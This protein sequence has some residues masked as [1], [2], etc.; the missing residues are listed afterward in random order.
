VVAA[1][2][3]LVAAQLVIRGWAAWGGF[4][5][6][7]DFVLQSRSA[8]LS[9][10]GAELLLTDVDGRLMPAGMVV[11]W[12]TTQVA[13]LS[14]VGVVIGLVVMQAV[15]SLAVWA[16][17][18]RL[19]GSRTLMLVPLGLYLLT[20]LT[21]PSFLWWTSALGS[22]PLQAGLALAVWAHVGYLRSGRRSDLALAWAVTVGALAFSEKAALIPI[23]LVGVTWILDRHDGTARSLWWA[24]AGRWRLW[25]A[26]LVVVAGYVS[27]YR[28]TVGTPPSVGGSTGEWW[29]FARQGFVDAFWVPLVGGPVSWLPVGA[30]SALA[31]PPGW[32][33]VLAAAALVAVV[34]S[35]WRMSPRA[36]RA[37]LFVVGYVAVDLVVIAAVRG[38]GQ[39]TDLAPLTLRYTADAAVVA[40]I[41]VGVS[42]MSSPGEPEPPRRAALLERVARRPTHAGLALFLVVDVF[43]L[44]TTISTLRLASIWAA[45]PAEG[46]VSNA[47]RTLAEAPP[48]EPV[49]PQPVPDTVLSPFAYPDNLTSRVLA[50]V[51][52]PGQFAWQT[53]ALTAF[54]ASG[55]LLPAHVAG[56]SAPLPPD[57]SCWLASQGRGLVPLDAAL[58]PFEHVVRLAY[59]A[60][61]QQEGT[62]ALGGGDAVP[63]EFQRGLSDLFLVLTGGGT[64]LYVTLRELGPTVCISQADVGNVVP[65]PR[66]PS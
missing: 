65:G 44:L 55:T 25:L 53:S 9:F 24:L 47:T 14:Q 62:V 12:V 19:F 15:A 10:P 41:A 28:S 3:G 8:R 66:D 1:A 56:A 40:V 59:I 32:V 18:H 36:R 4:L 27:W 60:G 5:Y 35:S 31:D 17:L 33:T 64:R 7:D 42:L 22:L 63:V 26:W 16:M 2:W 20:P 37:W 50:P 23:A 6:A 29:R 21:L 34:G 52:R 39:V 38:G 58:P 45:N 46:W 51:A 49:I 30:V 54:D 57:G 43:L 48:N 13:P 11:A 61:S